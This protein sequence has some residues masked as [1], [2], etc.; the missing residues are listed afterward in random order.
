MM[1]MKKAIVLVLLL[2]GGLVLPGADDPRIFKGDARTAYRDPAAFWHDGVCHLYFTLVETEAD[3][4]VHSY[5]AQ[6]ESRDLKTWTK[7]EKITP[8][9]V[10]DYSSPGNVVRDGDDW[11]LCYQSYPRPGNRDD[12]IS[13]YGNESS[14][15]FT[16]RSKDLR[17]WTAPELI[18]VKGPKVAEKDM[19]RMIDPFLVHDDQGVWWC[20]YKQQGASISRSR[21]FKTWEY[22]G[23]TDAGENVCV[24][25]DGTRYL[26]MHSPQN[27]LG[28]KVSNDLRH[29]R[30]L[31]GLITL[32]QKQWSWAKGRLTAGFL[33][34]GRTIPGVG[35]WL[36]FFHG[37][38]PMDETHGGFDRNASVA[39]VP[40]TL[41]KAQIVYDFETGDLQG[42]KVTEGFFEKAV[43]DRAKEHNSGKPYVKGGKWF[44]TTLENRRDE[45]IAAQMGRVQSPLIRLTSPTIKFRLGGGNNQCDFCLVDRQTGEIHARAVG[46]NDEPLLP[47]E[48]TVP[49]A[50]GREVFFCLS[51]LSGGHWAYIAVDDIVCEGEVLPDDFST[52]TIGVYEPRPAPSMYVAAETAVRELGARFPD[53]PAAKFLADFAKLKQE[54]APLTSFEAKRVE[55]LVRANPI[56]NAHEILYTT[57]AMWPGDHHN[58][59]SLFQCGEVNT[60]KYATQGALRALNPKTGL[61]RDIVG[62]ILARTVRDPEVDF[63]AK[64]I[65]FAMRRS[66]EED[67]HIWSVNVD[68]SDMRQLTS[69]KGVCDV[70]PAWLPDGG[71]VFT[72]TR[73]PKYCGCNRHIMAN[74]FRMEGDGANIHQIGRSTLFEEHPV[75]LADGRILYDRWEY[76]DRNFADAQALWT[77]NADGT[78]HALFWGNNTA[79]PGALMNARPLSDPSRAIAVFGSCHDRQWGA[80]GIV[81]RTKGVDGKEPVLRTWPSAFRDQ[82]RASSGNTFDPN[83]YDRTRRLECKYADPFPLDDEHFLCVRQT[84]HGEET[85]IFYLDLHGNEV[86]V[87]RDGLGCHDPMPIRAVKRPPVQSVQRNYADVKAPGR[88]YVQD[89]YVGTH[90]K[91]VKRGSIKSIRVVESPEKRQWIKVR[92]WWNDAA[93]TMNW[94]AFDAKRVLGTVPVAEDGSAYFEVPGNTYVF[95]QALDAEGKMV[96]SM[97]SGV[98]LQPGETYGCVGCHESRGG[99][100]PKMDKKG[101]AFSRAPAKLDG[102][103]NLRGLHRGRP[104]K[105]FSYQHEVQ[106]VF[107]RHCVACHDYGKPAGA[108]LNL[109]GDRGAYFCTSYVDLCAKGYVECPGDGP[110]E[111]LNAYS[112]GARASRLLKVIEGGHKGVK[113]ADD[114]REAVIAWLDLN[115]PY[116]PVY[117]CAWPDNYGGRMPI[118]C[119]EHDRLQQLAGRR[120]S[121]SYYSKQL[122]QL[123]FDRPE[124]SRILDPIRGKSAYAEALAIIQKGKERL[125]T[126]PRADMEGFVPC[127]AHQE[128]LRRYQ[129]R[130]DEERSVYDAIRSGQKRYDSHPSR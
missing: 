129:R 75:V 96:Q 102:A 98:I 8:R 39:V 46:R 80:L 89:V 86:L 11:V 93:C 53:Y 14:R 69:A 37:S 130:A 7:P 49:R 45:S 73:E 21:D 112:W 42:W 61:A 43:S 9:S 28:F 107:T 110:A 127:A 119:A 115:V 34:D 32:D 92:S 5:V 103:Y 60:Y 30:A 81:D 31:P 33:L 65:V 15:L 84:G 101:V 55:A 16:A 13:R 122:E 124:C 108:K 116:W 113:L 79:C 85:G 87:H 123:D 50:V 57:H 88:F 24:I 114:E 83:L 105:Q 48:W 40:F 29:W 77:C 91:G 22:I 99:D 12:G 82:I 67:Y 97:R 23:R 59:A 47:V 62:E 111:T 1:T 20:F 78:R 17:H 117:E 54:D 3:K 66:R 100:L 52:R 2:V 109:S 4:S 128:R 126:N 63:D 76:V 6:S 27:G 58:T 41:P 121:N 44:L 36:L 94:R 68:G 25:K 118:T 125:K 90:M 71:I 95:F 56:V 51:D 120:I 74:L 64:R 104:A 26:M 70:Q 18:R 72:S 38:G 19:G 106:P 10:M 35:T